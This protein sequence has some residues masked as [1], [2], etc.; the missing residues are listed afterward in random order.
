MSNRSSTLLLDIRH[1]KTDYTL[2]QSS[3]EASLLK[4][5]CILEGGTKMVPSP[6]SVFVLKEDRQ[7]TR[8][9]EVES[10]QLIPGKPFE[11]HPGYH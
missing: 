2:Q 1:S 5:L 6:E 7:S 4:G 10:I 9:K 8:K 3:G 11:T